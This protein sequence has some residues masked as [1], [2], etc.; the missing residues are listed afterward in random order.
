MV[1]SPSRSRLG[2]LDALRGL[3]AVMVLLFHYTHQ[4]PRVLKGVVTVPWHA[5]WGS[6]GVELFFAI[7]GFVILMTLERTRRPADFVVSRFARL[8]PAYWTAIALTSVGVLL[9]GAPSLAQPGGIIAVNLTM[10]QAFFYLPSVDGVYWSLAVELCFYACMLAVCGL[11]W[12]DRIERVLVPW[13]VLG[14]L[15]WA[16][17]AL[18][19]RIGLLLVVEYM[20]FFAVGMLAY[21]VHTGARRWLQ[22]VPLLALAFGVLLLTSTN[23]GLITFSLSLA[24]FALMVEQRLTLIDQAPLVWLGTISYSVYLIHQNLGYALIARMEGLGFSPVVATLCTIAAVIAVAA[25]MQRW[26]EKPA[27]DAIRGWWSDRRE[28]KALPAA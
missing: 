22:Q 14:V 18:P 20:P 23:G 9:L 2:E 8:F 3:A 26:V 28:A 5:D 17:P 25:A 13:L 21:R 15:W 1:A 19:S 27:L 4:A 10:T 16:A 7:S 6:Y 11:R 12:L 24:A